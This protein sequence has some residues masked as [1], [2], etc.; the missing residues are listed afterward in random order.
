MLTA[1]LPPD[2]PRIQPAREIHRPAPPRDP[3]PIF[4]LI[5]DQLDAFSKM[6]SSALVSV[7]AGHGSTGA[8]VL[9]EDAMGAPATGSDDDAGEALRRAVEVL[10]REL[11]DRQ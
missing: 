3:E 1:D 4:S 10:E 7:I 2:P 5:Q 8:S 11:G 6:H 9:G